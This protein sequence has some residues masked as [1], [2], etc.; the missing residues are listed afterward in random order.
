MG[1]EGRAEKKV[2]CCQAHVSGGAWPLASE[3]GGMETLKMEENLQMCTTET[4]ALVQCKLIVR[5]RTSFGDEQEDLVRRVDRSQPW[6]RPALR[7]GQH[8]PALSAHSA[9]SWAPGGRGQPSPL[10][11]A[12]EAVARKNSRGSRLLQALPGRLLVPWRP[13]RETERSET[14]PAMLFSALSSDVGALCHQNQVTQTQRTGFPSDSEI[15]IPPANAGDAGLIPGSGP[16]GEGNG[17]TLQYSC[18]ENPMD[19]GA[20][21]AIIHGVTES[22]MT[23]RLN[24]HNQTERTGSRFIGAE[25]TAPGPLNFFSLHNPQD[26]GSSPYPSS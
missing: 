9:G 20:W 26:T 8:L 7:C 14:P 10:P 13:A 5:V 2:R 15:K 4:R 23:E 16:P 19:R 18:L 24:H 1:V 22:D 25:I 17:N 11:M 6:A 3:H 21:W 12:R